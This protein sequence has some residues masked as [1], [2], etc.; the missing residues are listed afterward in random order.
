MSRI[1]G[2]V[3]RIFSATRLAVNVGSQ[4]GVTKGTRF[5][6]HSQPT[7]IS[8]TDGAALGSISFVRGRVVATHVYEKFSIV[9]TEVILKSTLDLLSDARLG[10]TQERLKVR[11]SDVEAVDDSGAVRIGD[12][13]V[14]VKRS[15]KTAQA[16]ANDTQET[17]E[18]YTQS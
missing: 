13:V 18:Q 8:D 14:E 17:Q 9:G 15:E 5:T 10:G 4:A 1:E 16:K 2:K 3:V 11:S 12:S 6:I 7:E